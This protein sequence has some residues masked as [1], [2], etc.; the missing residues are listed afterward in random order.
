MAPMVQNGSALQ[1]SDAIDVVVRAPIELCDEAGVVVKGDVPQELRDAYMAALE[2]EV[3][4][5]AGDA[6]GGRVVSLR[7]EGCSPA[8]MSLAAWCRLVETFQGHYRGIDTARMLFDVPAALVTKKAVAYAF[9]FRSCFN[10]RLDSMGEQSLAALR[11]VRA[12]VDGERFPTFG[13]ELPVGALSRERADQAE[14][15][16]EEPNS[17]E[18]PDLPAVLAACSPGYVRL[19][20]GPVPEGCA[21]DLCAAGLGEVAPGLFADSPR[22][23]PWFDRSAVGALMGFGLGAESAY[24]GARFRT[25]SDPRAYLEGAGLT[26]DIYES[27]GEGGFL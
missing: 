11:R 23:A 24:A 8:N 25:T 19:T 16:L 20:G 1:S 4:S 9:R 12:I 3:V 18:L 5:A 10:V 17:A 27:V 2:R 26:M 15:H 6:R 22:Y 13:V 7:F 21:R 14:P